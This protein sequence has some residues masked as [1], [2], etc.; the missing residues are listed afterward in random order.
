[1][2]RLIRGPGIAPG[3]KPNFFTRP[4]FEITFYSLARCPSI[5]SDSFNMYDTI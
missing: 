5:L 3:R 4:Y 2:I 1:M